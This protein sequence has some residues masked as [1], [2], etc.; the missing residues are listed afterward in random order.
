MIRLILFSWL[1]FCFSG[2]ALS[3]AGRSSEVYGERGL[4]M[5][6]GILAELDLP[7]WYWGGAH[8][9]DNVQQNFRL[10]DGSLLNRY[11]SK[12]PDSGLNDPQH[13]LDIE[14]RDK[15]EA[16]ISAHDMKSVMPLYVHVLAYGQKI[17]LSE[18]EIKRKLSKAYKGQNAMVIIYYYGYARGVTG[19]V[20]LD[21]QGFI[22]DW[23]VD[24]L[25]LKS[26]RD[27]SVQV[28]D[29]TELETFV[30]EFSKRS[31]W[32]EQK[33]IAP[34]R[35]VKDD[36]AKK[37]TQKKK[38]GI[39]DEWLIIMNEHTMTLVL[40]LSTLTAGAWYF[41]WSRIWRK[42]VLPD[43]NVSVRL[44]ADHGANISDLVEFSNA[45]ISLAEQ[46]K[47]LRGREL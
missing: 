46:Y 1:W 14:Q 5:T 35:V 9:Y 45:K 38:N 21:E 37:D 8:V 15:I 28:E 10:V 22:E 2:F 32:L 20:L 16:L 33:L 41:L 34:V 39:W 6:E 17:S 7:E 13:L 12:I 47:K 18:G 25:F 26:A 29:F 24:Q 3:Q 4:K 43:R 30:R 44:G 27:A 31:F 40:A 42:Y 23:E 19:Y 36:N 11:F